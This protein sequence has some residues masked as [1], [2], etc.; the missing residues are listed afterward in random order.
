MKKKEE[1]KNHYLSY[2]LPTEQKNKAGY[3]EEITTT[4][5]QYNL[6]MNKQSHVKMV[7]LF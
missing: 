4:N 1:E 2:I 6:K 5:I 3:Q 7:G